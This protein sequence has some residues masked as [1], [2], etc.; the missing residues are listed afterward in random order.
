MADSGWSY[1]VE[2][3]VR[4]VLVCAV[5]L[6]FVL[7]LDLPRSMA[8]AG[9]VVAFLLAWRDEHRQRQDAVEHEDDDDE[10]LLYL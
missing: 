6:T 5:W 2:V 4:A 9:V 3:I 7:A 10:P 8:V 1:A